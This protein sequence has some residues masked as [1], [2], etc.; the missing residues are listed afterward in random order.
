MHV[1]NISM[2]YLSVN[3]NDDCAKYGLSGALKRLGYNKNSDVI[4]CVGTDSVVGDSL[5]PMVGSLLKNAMPNAYVYG[6]LDKPITALNLAPFYNKIKTMHPKSKI[7]VI[8]AAVGSREDVGV[9]KVI[10]GAICPGLGV[11]KSLGLIGDIGIIG[12]VTKRSKLF[13]EN[14]CS[15]RVGLI[16]SMASLISQSILMC[17]G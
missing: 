10:N 3:L 7:L 5:A 2:S 15:A 13:I 11:K 12:I 8:D 4:M 1:K 14:L 17:L 9:V 16:Y 6:T